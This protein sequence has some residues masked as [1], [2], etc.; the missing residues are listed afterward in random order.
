MREFNKTQ[1]VAMSSVLAAVYAVVTLFA[2]VPQ[3]EA[4]QLRFADCLEVLTFFLGWPGVIGL[5]VGC[6]VANINSPYPLD[7]VIGTFSTFA[8]TIFIMY[9][10][11]KSSVENLKRDLLFSMIVSSG[12]TGAI[13]GYLLWI[14][15]GIP[16]WFGAVTVALSQLVAKVV[17]GYPVGLSLPKFAPGVFHVEGLKV[18]TSGK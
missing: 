10:G 8:S 9:V 14:S 12:I 4:V 5:S 6:L 2:P 13:I 11:K 18:E 16:L 17:I 7:V 15:V 3:Y 1:V